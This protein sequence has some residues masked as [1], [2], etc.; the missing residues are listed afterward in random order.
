MVEKLTAA[1]EILPGLP[2][3]YEKPKCA[4]NFDLLNYKLNPGKILTQEK[5]YTIPS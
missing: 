4:L 5:L 2:Y 1:N 3:V